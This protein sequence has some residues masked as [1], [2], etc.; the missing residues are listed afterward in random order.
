M[1]TKVNIAEAKAQL[2]RLVE[3]VGR[4]EQVVIARSGRPVAR[5]LPFDPPPTRELGFVHMD[6]PDD[7]F[8]A[9]TEEE[10]ADWE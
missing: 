3:S 1:V 5:L 2:S 7:V 9:L 4:G 8:D 6:V 10:L